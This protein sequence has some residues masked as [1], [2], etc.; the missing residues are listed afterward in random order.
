M[1]QPISI[2]N[3]PCP[4][5]ALNKYLKYEARHHYVFKQTHSIFIQF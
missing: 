5:K 2:H 4:A 3:Y 1:A